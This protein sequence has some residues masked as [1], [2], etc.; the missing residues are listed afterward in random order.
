MDGRPKSQQDL[1]EPDEKLEEI[2]EFDDDEERKESSPPQ[3]IQGFTGQFT[4]PGKKAGR[5]DGHKVLE[6]GIREF[7][8]NK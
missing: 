1:F 6:E 3:A 4:T 5:Q 7:V 2:K 8:I